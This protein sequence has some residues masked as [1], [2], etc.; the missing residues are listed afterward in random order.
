[1]WP[2]VTDGVAWS[3]SQSVVIASTA[4]TAELI[5][6]SFGLWTVVGPS[7]HVLDEGCTLAQPGKYDGTV[8]VCR[9]CSLVS[10]YFN[11]LLWPPC[12]ADADIIFL[13]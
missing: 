2:V 13:P 8:R 4:K 11:H 7:N 6:M 5:E 3:L 10:N 12:I 1:M 9:R